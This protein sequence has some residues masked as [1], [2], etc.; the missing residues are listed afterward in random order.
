M[1]LYDKYG[2]CII[3]AGTKLYKGGETTNY[4]GCIFFGLQKYVAAAFQNNSGKIQIWTVKQDIKILFMVQELN[5]SSWSKSAIVDIYKEYYPSENVLNDLDIK[6]RDHNKRD[7]L[8]DKLKNENIMGWLSSLEGKVDLEICLF[9]DKREFDQLMELETVINI[10]NDK[11][12][13]LNALDGIDLNPSEQFFTQ[14]KNKLKDSPFDDY[15][16][17]VATWT[18]DEIKQGLTREQAR[19]Y[20]LNLRTK[21]KI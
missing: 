17:M 16:K 6:H 7:K 8:I 13:Y 1:T 12:D 21:F 5:H 4:D 19:H 20:H 9:P 18:E 10:D 3:P 11:F 15:A 2:H 14:T